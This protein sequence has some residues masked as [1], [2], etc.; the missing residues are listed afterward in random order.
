MVLACFILTCAHCKCTCLNVDSVE[1]RLAGHHHN[2]TEASAL[3]PSNV[4]F[5]RYREVKIFPWSISSVNLSAH[6]PLSHRSFCPTAAEHARSIASRR[7]KN[8][9]TPSQKICRCLFFFLGRL[10]SEPNLVLGFI[11]TGEKKL[12]LHD[13]FG[14]MREV[15]PTCVLDFYVHESCK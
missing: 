2:F 15:T 4:H 14:K 5:S 8:V 13:N 10:F 9:N 7:H 1:C 12:F 3:R 6:P 11:K